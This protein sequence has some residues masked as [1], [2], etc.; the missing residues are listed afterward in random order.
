[1]PA[2]LRTVFSFSTWSPPFC[3]VSS[4]ELACTDVPC[5]RGEIDD[6]NPKINPFQ[7]RG[8]IEPKQYALSVTFTPAQGLQRDN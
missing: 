2:T 5:L 7:C 1:M 6:H 8:T 3:V 4:V